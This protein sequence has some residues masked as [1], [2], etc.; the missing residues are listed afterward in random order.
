MA[1]QEGRLWVVFNR[2]GAAAQAD[3]MR[4]TRLL[5]TSLA[6]IADTSSKS[7]R[8]AAVRFDDPAAIGSQPASGLP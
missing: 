2:L 5:T 1:D 6:D 4:L 8:R 3:C 7:I